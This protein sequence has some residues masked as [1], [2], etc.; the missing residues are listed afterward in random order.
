MICLCTENRIECVC[1]CY[2]SYVVDWKGLGHVFS[3]WHKV[4]QKIN[5]PGL[6]SIALCHRQ[7]KPLY[8]GMWCQKQ[9]ERQRAIRH[10]DSAIRPRTIDKVT[11]FLEAYVHNERGI[12][13]VSHVLERHKG[14]QKFNHIRINGM[15]LTATRG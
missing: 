1:I 6:H 5:R 14:R 2:V 9:H 15:L 7:P 10:I 13:R 4:W 12:L 3:I 11:T 8:L